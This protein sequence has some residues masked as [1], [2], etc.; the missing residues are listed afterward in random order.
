MSL[1]KMRPGRPY[2]T[3]CTAIDACSAYPKL[4]MVFLKFNFAT[5]DVDQ[6]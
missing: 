5:A 1:A 3:H 6:S 4:R 2:T